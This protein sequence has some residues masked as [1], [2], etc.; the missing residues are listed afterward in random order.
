[1]LEG[2]CVVIATTSSF[3]SKR[4]ELYRRMFEAHESMESRLIVALFN[5][6]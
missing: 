5:Q 4:T 2:G 1:M 6:G 3:G